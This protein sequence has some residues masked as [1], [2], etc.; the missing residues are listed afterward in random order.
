MGGVTLSDFNTYEVSTVE[1]RVRP[2]QICP[3]NFKLFF[4]FFNCGEKHKIYHLNHFKVYSSVVLT[5]FILCKDLQNFSSLTVFGQKCKN[6]LNRGKL[7][8]SVNYIGAVG[9]SWAEN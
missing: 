5:I 4:E 1:S 3:T 6:Y 9:H 8:F 7:I 2:I